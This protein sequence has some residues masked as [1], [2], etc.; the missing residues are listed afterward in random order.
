[1]LGTLEDLK[2][3]MDIAATDVSRDG[4]LTLALET[5]SVKV[6]DL[7]R[8][9]ELDAPA[10]KEIFRNV[11]FNRDLFTALRPI[12]N[13]VFEGRA[14]GESVWST[15]DGDVID[16]AEGRIILLGASSWWPPQQ[17]TAA[18]RRWR[19]PVWPIIRVT[20]DVTGFGAD[21]ADELVDAACSLAAFWF[22]RDLAGASDTSTI[23]PVSRKWLNEGLPAPLLE[24]LSKHTK[25]RGGGARWV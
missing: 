25:K 21:P 8:Y 10:T 17:P 3:K 20:Y 11:Q 5:A 9:A 12:A 6:L 13:V 24:K 22:D 15:L 16:P 1:M 23:G 4:A 14:L 18:F 19:D 2:G 7:C